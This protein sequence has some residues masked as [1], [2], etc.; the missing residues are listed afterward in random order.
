MCPIYSFL[1]VL[2]IFVILVK[3]H[4]LL[5]VTFSGNK[6]FIHLEFIFVYGVSWWL[7]FF[8]F[9][10]H[11]PAQTPN[12]I[13]W[14]G[15]F[16]SIVCS[17]PLCPILTGHRDMGLFLGSVFCSTDLCVCSYVNTRLFTKNLRTIIPVYVLGKERITWVQL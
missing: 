6:S 11:I 8:F 15:Y 17:C 12:T 14:R 3:D 16:Y 1:A 13:C 2:W 7:G 9:F 5:D 4:L 10:F